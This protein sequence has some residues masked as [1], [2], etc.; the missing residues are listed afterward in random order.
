MHGPV[1]RE[2]SVAAA[3]AV[4]GIVGMYVP[5][6]RFSG[7]Y[8]STLLWPIPLGMESL[9]VQGIEAPAVA[10]A[11]RAPLTAS[12]LALISGSWSPDS[13]TLIVLSTGV[14]VLVGGMANRAMTPVGSAPPAENCDAA[15][16]VAGITA[17]RICP[18]RVAPRSKATQDSVVAAAVM[19]RG[20]RNEPG[21]FFSL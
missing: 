2:M 11:L 5:E 20:F 3:G 6:L 8:R 9:L 4:I 12:I 19:E 14:G 13:M 15:L 17:M 7:E 10:L 1:T 16:T 18:Q 21:L